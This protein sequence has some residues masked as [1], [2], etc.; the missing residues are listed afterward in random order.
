MVPMDP[1][2]VHYGP[3]QPPK[4]PPRHAQGPPKG[5]YRPPWGPFCRDILWVNATLGLLFCSRTI[6]ENTTRTCTRVLFLEKE[7]PWRAPV[8]DGHTFFCIFFRDCLFLFCFCFVVGAAV[9][10]SLS[11]A[12]ADQE[13]GLPEV[14]QG[15]SES[16][17]VSIHTTK[18]MILQGRPFATIGLQGSP[19][20]PPAPPKAPQGSPKGPRGPLQ[21][22]PRAPQRAPEDLPKAPQATQG[23]P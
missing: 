15:A 2:G 6:C 3:L 7:P 8:D 20:G 13:L 16:Q 23:S 10:I 19:L 5:P 22:R 4:G 1:P 11:F 21:G 9:S 18:P 12:N 14:P 17:N